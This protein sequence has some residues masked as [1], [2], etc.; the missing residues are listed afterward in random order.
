MCLAVPGKIIS[1][2]PDNSGPKMAKVDFGGIKKSV[3]VDWLPEAQLGDY[4]IVH[5]G[6]ALSI[7]DEK[8]AE[9]T[10]EMLKEINESDNE[11]I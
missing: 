11:L 5:V 6:F 3:C 9:A 10:L 4:V 8:E 1:F 2:E 7:I